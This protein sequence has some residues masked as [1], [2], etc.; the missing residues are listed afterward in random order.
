MFPAF[1]LIGVEMLFSR[2][3]RTDDKNLTGYLFGTLPSDETERLDELSVVDDDF[4][5]RLDAVEND[6]VDAYV[7]GELAGDTLEKFQTRYLS[8]PKRREKVKFAETLC[9]F[10]DSTSS[11]ASRVPPKP[12]SD[13]TASSLWPALLPFPRWAFAGALAI[14]LVT[15]F[16]LVDN[17]ALRRQTSQAEADRKVLQQREHDLQARLDEQH[18]SD[19]VTASELEQVRK[20]LAQ[21]EQNS[22]SRQP[23]SAVSSFPVSVV[24]FVL[25]PQL[26]GGAK[27]A[28]LSLPR[29][30]TR[31]DLRLELEA[32]D[33]PQY[34]AA[35]KALKTGQIV[36]H[37]GELKAEIKGQDST[38]RI[39]LPANLLKH[40]AYLLEITGS[41]PKGAAEFVS[42]YVFRI[43]SN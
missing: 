16:L 19:A 5:A 21:L 28:D 38:V 1:L 30:T 18:A 35:L 24:A 27:I 39:S 25:S 3:Q 36:W 33:F 2:Q 8:S 42:S 15:T 40:E 17:I 9:S 20:S 7:R 4:A 31:V 29:G 41:Q 12:I 11:T 13:R 6:L 10:A 22:A 14:L 23:R 34:H 26:R 37:S 43:G 32:N